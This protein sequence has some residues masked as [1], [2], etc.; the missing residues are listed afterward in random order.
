MTATSLPVPPELAAAYALV[1]TSPDVRAARSSYWQRADRPTADGADAVVHDLRLA[2]ARDRR[3]AEAKAD[4]LRAT[5][6]AASYCATAA[7]R[8]PRVRPRRMRRMRDDRLPHPGRGRRGRRR[9]RQADPARGRRGVP[10]E[11]CVVSPY[12]RLGAYR[13]R[14]LR[15]EHVYDPAV[16]MAMLR[17]GRINEWVAG[18]QAAGRARGRNPGSLAEWQAWARAAHRDDPAR[19]IRVA[20]AGHPPAEAV[21]TWRVRR[22]ISAGQASVARLTRPLTPDARPAHN[23]RHD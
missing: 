19:H 1:D 10:A 22:R 21:A 9:R 20:R 13:E 4:A 8:P 23:R 5:M 6:E 11:S 3:E 18:L 14:V 2:L 7:R 16:H 12:G 15:G 17:S